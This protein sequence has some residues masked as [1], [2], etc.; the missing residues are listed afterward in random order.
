MKNIIITAVIMLF[1]VSCTN[2]DTEVLDKIPD[3]V[4]PENEAQLNALANPTYAELGRLVFDR[5]GWWTAQEFTTDELVIPTRGEHWVDGGKWVELHTHTWGN[6]KETVDNMWSNYYDGVYQANFALDLMKGLNASEALDISMAKLRVMRAFYYWLLL[7]NYGDVPVTFSNIDVPEKP[8]RIKR[9]EVWQAI[10]NDLEDALPYVPENAPKPIAGKA[11]AYTL[12][13]KLYLNAEVYTGTAHWAEAEQYCDSVIALGQFNLET[14]PLS[15]FVTQ[16]ES[17]VENIF[18]IPFDEDNM[19]GYML[20]LQT[21]HYASKATFDME[22][23]PWNGAAVTEAHFN[24]YDDNDLRKAYFMYGQQYDI[25][26]NEI[27]D[28]SILEPLVLDPHIPALVMGDD[29]T[30]VEKLMSG[31]RIQK[32]EIRI[33]AKRNLSNDFP[34]F[35]YADVLLMKAEAMIRQG[36]NGDEYVNMIRQRAGLESWSGVTLEQLYEERGREMFYEGSRRQDMIR[37]GTFLGTW[38]EKDAS[39]GDPLSSTGDR[40]V[41]PVP[42][43]AIDGNDNLTAPAISLSEQ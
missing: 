21:L 1:L 12:L 29:N 32:I 5:G 13:A 24:T 38:W 28:E 27:E 43:W 20:H 36:K 25:N 15:P 40:T 8:Y 42:Q 2:L 11:M 19:K 39:T 14:N 30:E 35:R 22:E 6:S 4:F 16:N 3:D 31:A 23:I 37:F 18:T 34:I 17:S 7:D 10:V 9:A 33:G 26:G 41:F